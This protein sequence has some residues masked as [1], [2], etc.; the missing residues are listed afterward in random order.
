MPYGH[1]LNVLDY[2]ANFVQQELKMPSR[3]FPARLFQALLVVATVLVTSLT[4]ATPV[5]A[6]TVTT[7]IFLGGSGDDLGTSIAMDGSGNIYVCGFGSATW[8][9]PLRAFAGTSD[10]FVAK[11][12]A[13]GALLWNTFLGGSGVDYGAGIAV[14][15]GGNA[16]VCGYSSSTWGSPLRAYGGGWDGFVAKLDTDGAL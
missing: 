8:G 11:L 4:A 5:G 16:Y 12:D 1:G 13:S 7:T 9:S 2:L 6:T 10:I 3:K 14:D 15:A